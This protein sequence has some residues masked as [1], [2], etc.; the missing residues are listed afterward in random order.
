MDKAHTWILACPAGTNETWGRLSAAFLTRF[1]LENRSHRARNMIGNFCNRPGES[2]YDGYKRFGGFLIN[3]PHHGFTPRM[4]VYSEA[5][6]TELD[7]TFDGAF[8][9]YEIEDTWPLLSSAHHAK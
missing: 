8:M 4:L 7:S 5:N 6:R 2:L 3:F 9:N 1:Y